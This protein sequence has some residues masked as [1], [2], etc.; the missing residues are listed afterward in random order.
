MANDAAGNIDDALLERAR[1]LKVTVYAIGLD[2]PD[3]A[4]A[5]L[6][7][8]ADTTGG[9]YF[10]APDAA[11]LQTIFDE[12]LEQIAD[13]FLDL[14]I[15]VASMPA[16]PGQSVPVSVYLAH[17]TGRTPVAVRICAWLSTPTHAGCHK[18]ASLKNNIYLP[19]SSASLEAANPLSTSITGLD[20]PGLLLIEA[21]V[22]GHPGLAKGN[23]ASPR[24]AC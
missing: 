2:V 21:R 23:Y 14:R 19:K 6:Q 3:E 1:V 12:I 20:T 18:W 7:K 15:P 17:S 16:S 10:Q 5:I 11:S 8:T 4:R 13:V 9:R 24:A 22:I